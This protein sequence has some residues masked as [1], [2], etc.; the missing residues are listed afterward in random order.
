MRR[1]MIVTNA[2][3]GGGAERSMNLLA[4]EL[5]FRGWPV[6]LVPINAGNS[7]LVNPT[8]A[9]FPLNRDSSG[10]IFST[11][12]A[13]KN[14]YK[15]LFN[16]KPDILILNCDLPELFGCAAIGPISIIGIEHSA[17]PW[18]KRRRLGGLVRK[19]LAFRGVVWVAVSSHL[20]IWGSKN[21]P[22]AV[23]Q[24][25][26]GSILDENI[27]YRRGGTIKRLVFVGRL[28]EE[29]NPNIAVSVANVT[30]LTLE[31]FGSGQLEESLQKEVQQYKINAIFN[32]HVK[33]PWSYLQEGDLLIVPSATEGDGLVILEAFQRGIPL[34]LA[35]IPDLRRFGLLD[36][37]Y[38]AEINDYI[39]RIDAYRGD[40][41]KLCP[42]VEIVKP[43]LDERSLSTICDDW[44]E[45]LNGLLR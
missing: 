42:S 28:A 23:M 17:I 27:D 16:W 36:K 5:D 32:G 9:T 14:F 11:I 30:K 10:S 4:S 19:V 39:E 45:L 37:N 26:L 31:F 15:A 3:S 22:A 20:G 12:R 35:D 41:S 44:E 7:D 24:N 8:C 38:C 18:I 33:D 29:K 34:L 40:I 43:I 25:P 13:L 21:G 2:L 1:V 6:A